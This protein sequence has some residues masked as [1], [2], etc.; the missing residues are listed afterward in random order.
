MAEHSSRNRKRPRVKGTKPE[1]GFEKPAPPEATNY[2]H[3]SSPGNL[4]TEAGAGLF[5]SQAT[6][7]RTAQ[8]GGRRTGGKGYPGRA[9]AGPARQTV[10]RPHPRGSEP[11]A[12]STDSGAPLSVPSDSVG[13]QPAAPDV[14]E[15]ADPN[16]SAARQPHAQNAGDV[17]HRRR[18]DP[19]ASVSAVM[20]RDLD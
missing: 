16:Y 15:I 7:R 11:A 4:E 12:T 18:P 6:G 1:P 10:H 20:S 13:P 14:P 19:G 3:P 9:A 8:G 17:R 5:E 2:Q